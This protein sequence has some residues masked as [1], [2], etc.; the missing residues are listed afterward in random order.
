MNILFFFI[1]FPF[2]N[3]LCFVKI[4]VMKTY[5]FKG[6][7]KPQE[8]KEL[9]KDINICEVLPS[10]KTV[11]IPVTMGGANNVPTVKAGDKVVKGQIIADS[12]E[13]ISAPV[14]ASISG[15][16][17]EIGLH[18]VSGNLKV[19]CITIE[20]D[21]LDSTSYREP[22]DPFNCSSKDAL[23]RIRDAGITGQGGASFPLHVK[24]N[25]PANTEVKYIILNAAE[26]EPYITI[27]YRTLKETPHRVIDGLRIMMKITGA[28][29]VIALEDNKIDLLE[30]LK[31]EILKENCSQD[32]EIRIVKS[33]YPQGSEKMLIKSLFNKE[34]PSGGLPVETGC[35]V[36]NTGTACA[37]S[38][39][40]RLGK[41]LIER[42]LTISG[43][44]CETP[45]NIIV[46][47]GT[48]VS[49]LVPEVVKI[50]A[51]KTVKLLSGGPLMG[52][53]MI[54]ADF[55]IAKGTAC[56]LFLTKEEVNTDPEI[57]CI[58][59][60]K[61]ID[62][63]PLGLAPTLIVSA[64]KVRNIEKAGKLGVMDCVECGSCGFICPANVPLVQKIRLGKANVKRQMA[65]KTA[66]GKA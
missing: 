37:V 30:I 14:H 25:P 53:S 15:T 19:S 36:S 64:L 8:C 24:L 61:C 2:T 56:V 59:C 6:G 13:F 12:T 7:V 46:P 21:G 65:S 32:I 58:G 9:S 1:Y 44:A 27:D 51:E 47:V 28:K 35:I 62:V 57:P 43:G 22:L 5:T 52:S 48:I 4:K 38:D 11:T 26:C 18:L 66:G 29:G 50:N 3:S 31:T 54:S 17:K 63:C 41:P 10:S 49:D 33:K 60:G 34:V 16:V 23:K 42:A 40:F 39:A 55:P 45:K 20:G